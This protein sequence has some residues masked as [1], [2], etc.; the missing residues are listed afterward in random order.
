MWGGWES[1][2]LKYITVKFVHRT[3]LS[4]LFIEKIVRLVVG[5][6]GGGG[7]V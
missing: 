5:G 1:R 4:S 7:G 6:S 3:S 2:I